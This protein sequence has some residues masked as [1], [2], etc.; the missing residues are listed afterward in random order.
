MARTRSKFKSSNFKFN[1]FLAAYVSLVGFETNFVLEAD[2][3]LQL[4][5]DDMCDMNLEGICTCVSNA[6]P[7]VFD[8][9][10]GEGR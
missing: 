1:L 3:T 2:A 7:S 8:D 6:S 10:A 5:P 9:I 4:L